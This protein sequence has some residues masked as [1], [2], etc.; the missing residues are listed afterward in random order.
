MRLAK[1]KSL[2]KIGSILIAT[3]FVLT[4][5]LQ[6]PQASYAQT[7]ADKQNYLDGINGVNEVFSGISST[8]TGA[9]DIAG[10][11]SD[12]FEK[13][14]ADAPRLAKLSKAFTT[15]AKFGSALGLAGTVFDA[16]AGVIGFI[17]PQPDPVLEGIKAIDQ[18]VELLNVKAD[19]YFTQMVTEIQVGSA[20]N[21]LVE[22]LS[23]IQSAQDGFDD[24]QKGDGLARISMVD[25]TQ[26]NSKAKIIRSYCTGGGTQ[27]VRE[28]L[29]DKVKRQKYGELAPLLKYGTLMN[30]GLQQ[31][32]Q[33]DT[34][35]LFLANQG[36]ARLAADKKTF[37]SA[38]SNSYGKYAPLMQECSKKFQ[39]TVTEL[40]DQKN[41]DYWADQYVAAI[42]S[43]L[44]V[45]GVDNLSIRSSPIS[46]VKELKR[47]YP[48]REWMAVRCEGECNSVSVGDFK[49]YKIV[50]TD[51][52]TKN[53]LLVHGWNKDERKFSATDWRQLAGTKLINAQCERNPRYADGLMCK[54]VQQA[55]TDAYGGPKPPLIS[56]GYFSRVS[57]GS[58]WYTSNSD[59]VV[60]KKTTD[61]SV[62]YIVRLAPYDASTIAA[63]PNPVPSGSTTITLPS[64]GRNAP[65]TTVTY[66]ALEKALTEK[67]FNIVSLYSNKCLEVKNGSRASLEAIQ[68]S[69]CLGAE[70]QRFKFFPT[71]TGSKT[72]EIRA[73]HSD[74]CINLNG[75][76]LDNAN[77][78]IQ[79]DCGGLAGTSALNNRWTINDTGVGV[80][81]RSERDSRKC[82][83]VAGPSTSNGALLQIW[84]CYGT[85]K[86]QLFAFQQI[87][88]TPER[89]QN[90]SCGPKRFRTVSEHSFANFDLPLASLGTVISFKDGA[91]NHYVFPKCNRVTW[92]NLSFSCGSNGQWRQNGSMDADAGCVDSNKSQRYLEVGDR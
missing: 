15:I 4:S 78:M 38:A 51:G 34:L 75:G 88:S 23:Y 6:F 84:D 64:P 11:L 33:S 18:K 73:E 41:I 19:T 8:A 87:A 77:K 85:A 65:G 26:I 89:T 82:L 44:A 30:V 9:S 72:Y 21:N 70:N 48:L 67:Y 50:G 62:N 37:K 55:I 29:L 63:I 57:S 16:L 47:K 66:T 80:Q 27:F 92:T 2:T 25:L 35:R 83:D 40:M 5:I 43:N 76:S 17:V 42:S 56:F 71:S 61:S 31:A 36:D 59:Q 69:D 32:Y 22:A 49:T 81:I 91:Y 1:R 14:S 28:S 24:Y 86:N 20:E 58:S 53:T 79:Y 39:E 68:Q 90:I 46:L 74:K 3:S 60:S 7:L 52:S 13:V 54:P 45:T 12:V 10:G